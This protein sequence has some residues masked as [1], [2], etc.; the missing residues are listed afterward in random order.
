M[1]R[2]EVGQGEHRCRVAGEVEQLGQGSGAGN[3]EGA[4]DPGHAQ[5]VEA[6]G[7]VGAVGDRCGPELA[8]EV[9]VVG[10]GGADDMDAA[11]GGELD[12]GAADAT[13]G[14]VDEERHAG[15]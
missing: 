2:G 9:V 10:A 3:V 12:G 6:G 14:A 4:V 11:G 8:E 1:G 13:G 7:E 5:G 15:P